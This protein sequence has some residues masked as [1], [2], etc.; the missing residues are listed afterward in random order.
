MRIGVMLSKTC[1]FGKNDVEFMV[2][3]MHQIVQ[4]QFFAHYMVHI[5]LF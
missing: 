3:I 1:I 4:H 2:L 5:A